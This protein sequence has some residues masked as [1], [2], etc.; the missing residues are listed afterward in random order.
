M[1]NLK[2]IDDERSQM[3]NIPSDIKHRDWLRHDANQQLDFF[4][5]S[6]T[7]DGCFASLNWDGSQKTNMSQELHTTTRMVHSYALGKAFGYT[8]ADNI[9][10]AGMAALWN[11]HRDQDNGGYAWSVDKASIRDGQKLAYG[12]V[13]VLLAAA[14]AKNAGHPDA[15][16]LISDISCILEKY[17]WDDAC[18][19]FREEYDADWTP[20]STYHGMNANMHGAEALLTAYEA[21]GHEKYLDHSGRI[22]DYF[23]GTIAPQ[24]D[25]RIPE[26]YTED[27]QIDTEYSGDLMF[28]P[29]GTTPGHSFE[30]G[31]LVIQHWDLTG[32]PNTG[33]LH[34][35]RHLIYKALSD[36]W[37]DEGGFCYTLN[38]NGEISI[39]DRYWWPVTEAI[40]ALSVCL[41]VDPTETDEI[42]YT[43]LWNFAQFNFV[44]AERGGWYPEINSFGD[45]V[46]RQF[47]GKPDIYHALQAEFI[48]LTGAPSNLFSAIS[49]S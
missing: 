26:H 1:K 37:L 5:Q 18:G 14:S 32:R 16:R 24:F 40:G 47:F 4:Y 3:Q 19:R 8:A 36:A 33:A 35:A 15:D 2:M 17:F 20:F 27:W 6:L 44:D 34:L 30:F 43:K 39:K 21:T 49:D 42:W 28:R 10:D 11:W 23:T 12:H 7:K 22:L 41:Q 38:L 25:W 46:G 29:A 9:I 31:R 45:P 48:A 13:F